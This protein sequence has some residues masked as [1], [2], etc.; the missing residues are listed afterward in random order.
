MNQP[1]ETVLLQE[2]GSLISK[3]VMDLL[4]AIIVQRGL[5][6]T[7][8]IYKGITKIEDEDNYVDHYYLNYPEDKIKL[9]SVS[10]TMIN[11]WSFIPMEFPKIEIDFNP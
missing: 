1:N 4:K 7:G 3:Q 9:F 8:L 5:E 2:L 11:P 10:T 6:A